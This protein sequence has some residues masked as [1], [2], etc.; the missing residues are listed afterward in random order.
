MEPQF[1]ATLTGT[2]GPVEGIIKHVTH[3]GLK[4]AYQF[5]A[6]DDTLHLVIAPD[7]NGNWQKVAG[8]E[9]YLFGWV[10]EMAEQ[11]VKLHT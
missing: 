2:E 3:G 10:D 9:P 1:K 7:E 8:I 4:R 5:D 11:I 6:I